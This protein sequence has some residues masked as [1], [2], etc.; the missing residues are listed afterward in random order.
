MAFPAIASITASQAVT[1]TT[2]VIVTLPTVSSGQGILL[3]ITGRGTSNGAKLNALAGYTEIYDDGALSSGIA[4][5]RKCDGTEGAT[6]TFTAN[7]NLTQWCGDVFLFNAADITD[8][9]TQPPQGAV[10]AI[11]AATDPWNQSGT[12]TPTGGAGQLQ[13]LQ[14]LEP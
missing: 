5:W 3:I 14:N 6:V 4:L 2:S 8:W 7:Q 12:L 11:T 10:T 9:A 1:G 13:G